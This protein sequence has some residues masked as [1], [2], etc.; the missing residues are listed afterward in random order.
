MT[1]S[2]IATEPDSTVPV[3]T[4]PAPASVNERSTAR[5]NRPRAARALILCAASN[6]RERKAST[7]SPVTIDTG[8]ISAS[9]SFVGASN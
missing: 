5:R 1:L 2:S 3:T 9:A 7:P 4:V 6:R 8:M